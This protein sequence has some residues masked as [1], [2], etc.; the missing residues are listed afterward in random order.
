MSSVI[1]LTTD[2]GLDDAYVALLKGAILSINGTA[3]I[4][5]ISHTIAP[6][7]IRQAAFLLHLTHA[8]FPEG[9]V[10]LVVVDP[11]VG[12][13]RQAVLVKTPH[14][15]FIAPD[16]GVLTYIIDE[17]CPGLIHADHARNNSTAVYPVCGNLEVV[18]ITRQTY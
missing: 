13:E 11:G 6:Q 15:F 2:F 10:H 16:N 12:S 18:A 1:T 17:Y 5:D 14:D 7:N 9:T 8:Y 4:V 3:Y